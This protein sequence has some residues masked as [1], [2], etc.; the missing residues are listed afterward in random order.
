[1]SHFS[2]QSILSTK[3]WLEWGFF[4]NYYGFDNPQYENLCRSENVENKSFLAY[5]SGD[6]NHMEVSIILHFRHIQSMQGLKDLLSN[7]LGTLHFNLYVC[8]SLMR[9]QSVSPLSV[10]PPNLQFMQ[11]DHIISLIKV[12]SHALSVK[13]V[14]FWIPSDS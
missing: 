3:D 4:W 12:A 13:N 6:I 1:M 5:I 11:S 8:S 10:S 9:G 2:F 7:N 14:H